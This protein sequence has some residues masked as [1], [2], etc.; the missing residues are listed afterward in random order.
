MLDGRWRH[1]VDRTTQPVGEALVRARVNADVLTVFGLVMSAVTAFVVGSGH[2]VL[3]IVMLFAT[4]LPDLFDGPVAKA[5]GT[6]SVRG[7][8]FDSV[9]D[10]VSDAFLYGGIAWYL[11]S[12]HHGTMVLL[13]FAILAMTSLI[14]YERAKAELLGLSARGGLMERAE[15]FILLGVCF[16]TAAVDVAAFVPALWVFFGLV[17]ATAGGR[18]ARTWQEAEGPVRPL[19]AA[20][21]QRP[22]RPAGEVPGGLS[23]LSGRRVARWRDLRADSR[24]KAWREALAQRDGN[25]VRAALHRRA[26]E[27]LSRWWARGDGEPS[28]RSG[29]TWRE[30]RQARLRAGGGRPHARAGRHSGS[31]DPDDIS[32][33]N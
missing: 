30:R 32:D 26:G 9:A 23:E 2:L 22:L 29:R 12:H 25:A 31:G 7:A 13:A 18:F 28:S 4:G 15:R 8:F 14:S 3:A 27:P 16:V 6:A 5:S 10:R 11:A 33:G 19:R 17:T 24:W 21:R 20:P 1:A